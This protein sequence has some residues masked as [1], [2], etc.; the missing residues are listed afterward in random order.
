MVNLL[1]TQDSLMTALDMNLT[2][3]EKLNMN[4]ELGE[5]RR[6]S[7][8]SSSLNSSNTSTISED[9][10]DSEE[11]GESEDSEENHSQNS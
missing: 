5:I 11:S 10:G 9:E 6:R 8:M 4:L 7:I 2:L 3:E 1:Q